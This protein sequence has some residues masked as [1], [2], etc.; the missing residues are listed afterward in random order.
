[1]RTKILLPTLAVFAITC[2]LG[3]AAIAWLFS[4]TSYRLNKRFTEAV[5]L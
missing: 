2:G 4:K 3:I 5:F 1:M